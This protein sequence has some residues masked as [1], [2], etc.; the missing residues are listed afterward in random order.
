MKKL[1]SLILHPFSVTALAVVICFAQGE[2]KVFTEEIWQSLVL[3]EII[4]GVLFCV[5][6]VVL[7]DAVR[8]GILCSLVVPT[9]FSYDILKRCLA[10]CFQEIAK[11]ELPPWLALLIYFCL[12]IPILIVVTR[13]KISWGKS[14]L[15]IDHKQLNVALNVVTLGLLIANCVPLALYEADIMNVENRYLDEFHHKLAGVNLDQKATKRDTYYI[16]LDSYPHS[17]VMKEMWGYDNSD[18]INFL[19]GHGFYV[20]PNA[21]SNYDRT[22]LSIPSTL[23]MQY[24]DEIPKQMGTGFFGE[25]VH[26][27]LMEDSCTA[28]LFKQLGYKYINVCCGSLDSVPEADVNYRSNWMNFFTMSM[29]MISPVGDIDRYIPF[30][31]DMYAERKLSPAKFIPQIIAA[32]PGPKFVLIH[33]DISHPPSIFGRHGEKKPLPVQIRLDPASPND[34]FEQLVYSETVAEDWINKILQT[35]GPK[36]IIIIQSDHGPPFLWNTDAAYYNARMKILNA[37]Y[38]PDMPKT[39]LYPT[40][41]PVNSFRTLFNDYFHAKLPM[42]PDRTFCNAHDPYNGYGWTETTNL[43]RF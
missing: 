19:K 20:V 18:F 2:H 1:S 38:F 15:E 11:S 32:H 41:T 12:V 29:L 5:L 24:L 7:K 26:W 3:F 22:H 8:A 4:V 42:L 28:R 10:A 33:S 6:S 27:R 36:P 13:Q 9:L 39:G 14:A 31:R 43:I 30:I 23:S 21:V 35:P 34:Y 40:I 17:Q 37:Y 16:I 25:L